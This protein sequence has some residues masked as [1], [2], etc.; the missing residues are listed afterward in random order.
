MVAQVDLADQTSVDDNSEIRRPKT[1]GDRIAGVRSWF[2]KEGPAT[3]ASMA[4]GVAASV[5][6]AKVAL[7][8]AP[9][10]AATA[11]GIAASNVATTLFRHIKE[12]ADK[13]YAYQRTAP[14]YSGQYSSKLGL[15]FRNAAR[16]R[17]LASYMASGEFWKR[18]LT[19]MAVSGVTFGLIHGASEA[20]GGFGGAHASAPSTAPTPSADLPD[21]SSPTVSCGTVT[22]DPSHAVA[23]APSVDPVEAT[24]QEV[25]AHN[26]MDQAKELVGHDL[27]TAQ[28]MKDAAVSLLKTHEDVAV[29]LYE[30]AAAMGNA[31]A[32]IDLAYLQYHGLHNVAGDQSEALAA[33]KDVATSTKG[34]LHNI[35]K[36]FIEQWTGGHPTDIAP[37]HVVQNQFAEAATAAQKVAEEA[38]AQKAAAI[39][40]VLRA[41]QAEE[42]ARNLAE[43]TAM[44][45]DMEIQSAVQN[46]IVLDCRLNVPEY[47]SP[48]TTGLDVQ[49]ECT[50]YSPDIKEGQS[51]RLDG[52]T[53]TKKFNGAADKTMEWAKDKMAW[54]IG[55]K[56]EASVEAYRG[57]ALQ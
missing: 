37:V 2:R 19:G 43:D 38:A 45:K 55:K 6:T 54:L 14:D 50:I 42:L 40:E 3:V 51:V 44:L 30:Q 46:G 16:P 20:F 10:L 31:Q 52:E 48:E 9:V 56:V 5:L 26:F 35:A 23:S 12:N 29:K 17:E 53:F 39:Q 27:T 7:A 11:A 41:S 8:A 47:I 49:P 57:L 13:E 4:I 18:A 24:M 34:A 1:L 33:M 36:E 32:R 21:C 25:D 15:W 22:P 28:D